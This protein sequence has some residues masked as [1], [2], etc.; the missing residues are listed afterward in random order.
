MLHLSVGRYNRVSDHQ[1]AGIFADEIGWHG[2]SIFVDRERE[3]NFL[4]TSDR[5]N[6]LA[7]GCRFQLFH[8]EFDGPGDG[9]VLDRSSHVQIR[10]VHLLVAENS[11][12][13][14]T[15]ATPP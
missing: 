12:V 9:V 7:F 10:G 11:E 6:P 1:T 8:A 15:A 13:W 4:L 3:K 5:C 14:K 2:R